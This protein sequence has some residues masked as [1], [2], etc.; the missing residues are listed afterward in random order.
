MRPLGNRTKCARWE[1]EQNAF[2]EME[3]NAS[4]KI[5]PIWLFLGWI[6]GGA[7]VKAQ[8]GE[9]QLVLT[10]GPLLTYIAFQA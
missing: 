9:V 5:P 4:T 7:R 6:F 3:Q 8:V 1:M 10:C 2:K